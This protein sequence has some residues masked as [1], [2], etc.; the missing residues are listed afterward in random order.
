[1]KPTINALTKSIFFSVLIATG[2]LLTLGACTQPKALVYQD[3]KGFKVQSLDLQQINVELDL[4]L[5]N[6][7]HFSVDLKNGNLD[8][9]IN[10]RSLG[11]ASIDERSTIPGHHSFIIPVTVHTTLSAL[12]ANALELL[13]NKNK[14]VYVSLSG[15]IRAGKRGIFVNVPI[16][17][18]GR[19]KLNL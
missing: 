14:S 8:A 6:P 1:M 15:N 19:Q 16:H 4:L 13:A 17:Y 7:N 5:Y 3:I 9:F 10:D 18:E 2:I 11:K 12:F